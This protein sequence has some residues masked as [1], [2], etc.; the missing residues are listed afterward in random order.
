[1]PKDLKKGTAAAQ[2]L[3]FQQQK[4]YLLIIKEKEV[5]G[6]IQGCNKFLAGISNLASK[7]ES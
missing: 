4:E 5:M 3:I 7:E 1:M 6:I 2:E